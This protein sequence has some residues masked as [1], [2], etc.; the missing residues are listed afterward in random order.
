MDKKQLFLW[1]LY[2]FANSIVFVNFILYFSQWIVIDQGL[3]DFWYN[4][5][6]VITTC[7]L[8]LTA[9]IL[10]SF[11]DRYG[12]KKRYL[13]IS[14]I[15][16]FLGYG[17]AALLA[18]IG[19][20][21]IF[22]IAFFFL[23]GQYFYLLSFTFYHPMLATIAD[24]KHRTRAS[25]IGQFANSI[26]QVAGIAITLPLAA[27][28]RLAPILPSILIFFVLALPMLILFK[29]SKMTGRLRIGIIREEV[30][31][32]IKKFIAFF[33]FSIAAPVIIAFFFFNDALVTLTNNYTIFVE[34]VFGI[35]DTQKSLLL[36]GILVMSAIGG[37]IGGWVGDRI[38]RLKT[39]KY[40]LGGW[41]IALPLIA[42]APN[43]TILAC[44][45]VIS[46]LLLGSIMAVMRAYLTTI[47][48]REDLGYGFSFYTLAERFATFLGPLT[49]GGIILILGTQAN[50]YRIAM[51]SMAVFIIIGLTVL[52]K[53]KRSSILQ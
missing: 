32:Y 20:F 22:L 23:I 25:G 17:A 34:R 29:E 41:I 21:P 2:D 18:N 46:G 31:M 14:T 30:R 39:I 44:L 33:S 42:I 35:P 24:E 37:V 4:A 28:S 10:A 8:L 11:T 27:H 16:A 6:F 48:P 38:G 1:S 53:W 3:P 51:A 49:W 43:F 15:G 36:L 50:S 7:M 52:I 40:I 12:G 26:G 13:N 47:I 9:P 19:G 5:I 45:S